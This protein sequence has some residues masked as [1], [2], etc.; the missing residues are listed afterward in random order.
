MALIYQVVG[1]MAIQ[2]RN[3]IK[4]NFD[5]TI[6]ALPRWAKRIGE[7]DRDLLVQ[8]LADLE[9]LYTAVNEYERTEQVRAAVMEF[10]NPE[11]E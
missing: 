4:R 3:E 11:A 7:Q 9:L 8:S 6:A 1:P 10:L 5:A 2:K